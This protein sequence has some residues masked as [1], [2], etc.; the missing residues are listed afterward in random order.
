[1]IV[2]AGLGRIAAI[3][4]S[5]RGWILGALLA[6]V[7]YARWQSDAS[8]QPTWLGLAAAGLWWRWLAGRHIRGHSNGLDWA[9]PVVAAD[10]PYRYGRHPLYLS[11]LAVIMGLIL[12]AHC[13]SALAAGAALALAFAHHAL[14]ARYEER[15]LSTAPGGAGAAYRSYMQVTPR[16]FGLP[17][18]GATAGAEADSAKGAWNRQGANLLKACGCAVLLWILAAIPR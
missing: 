12:Y 1:M 15:F 9:G 17:R 3:H 2:Q 6:A 14:L 18:A 5:W 11:N 10:G 7:A 4:Y 8:L 16:W 13:L